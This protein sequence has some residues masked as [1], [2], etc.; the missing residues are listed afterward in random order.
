MIDVRQL[1]QGRHVLGITLPQRG[2]H[3]DAPDA[4]FIPFWR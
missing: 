4:D 2:P 1:P 3:D